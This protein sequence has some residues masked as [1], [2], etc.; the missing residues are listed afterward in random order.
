MIRYAAL[1]SFTKNA[2]PDAVAKYRWATQDCM[3]LDKLPY[4]GRHRKGTN[5]LY[6]A[7][8]FNKW[9]MSGSMVASKLLTELITTGRSE[10]EELYSPQRSM[11]SKQLIVNIGEAAKRLLSVGGL[12]CTHMG[13]KLHR[14]ISEK[15]WD[16]SCHGSLFTQ[17]GHVITEPAKKGLK[18]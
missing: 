8:G 14:N 12:K 13:C 4:I 16:C 17:N 18:L 15:S 2:Y 1:E 6:V 7:A 11:L 10:L 5:N 9:G 3:S